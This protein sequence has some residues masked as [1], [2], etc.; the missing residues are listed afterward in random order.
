MKRVLFIPEVRQY[1]KTLVPILY[2]MGYF[3]YLEGSKK[4]VKELID[5]IKA[6]LPIC[7][8][9]PAP[10]HFNKYGKNM[11]YAIF[12][13]NKQTTWYAFFTKYNE[14]GDTIYLVRYIANNH[15]V[16]QYL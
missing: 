5:N 11:H 8:H 3:G 13:K 14:N 7:L 4:Y 9:K 12:R 1:V 6:N 16:A 15:T 2:N 10:K